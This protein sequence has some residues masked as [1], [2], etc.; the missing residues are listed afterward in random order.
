MAHAITT[1]V[2]A[3]VARLRRGD[4]VKQVGAAAGIDPRPREVVLL[5]RYA[6]GDD[7]AMDE[8]MLMYQQP[9]F[10]VARHLCGNDEMALDVVQDAFIRLLRHHARYDASRSTF[11]AWFLQIVRN[12]AIDHLR[13]A[14]LRISSDLA[15]Q[16]DAVP[17][18]DR[19][20]QD[21]LRDRIQAVIASLPE[22][23]GELLVLRDVEGISPQDIAIMTSTDYGTTRWRIHNA[24][25]LFRKEWQSR[26][27]DELP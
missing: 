1:S 4:A 15:D 21:E 12:M 22:P 27:G 5:E 18:P 3:M 10:W 24:R 16:L 7:G 23:Y 11:K 20:V 9:A 26:Y 6:A 17:R 8:L 13:K 14:R 19:V 25:K 2:S